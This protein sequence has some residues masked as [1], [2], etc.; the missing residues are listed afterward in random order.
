MRVDD[1][2][3]VGR[4]LRPDIKA[5]TTEILEDMEANDIW[6]NPAQLALSAVLFWMDDNN[7]RKSDLAQ[8]MGITE[9]EL[10]ELMVIDLKLSTIGKLITVT[11]LDLFT[12]MNTKQKI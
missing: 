5:R 8:K 3:I 1:T 6:R 4:I 2:K 11:G 12:I 9:E 7:V 10:A